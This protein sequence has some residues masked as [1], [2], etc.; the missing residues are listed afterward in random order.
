MGFH[1]TTF[2][3]LAVF[4]LLTVFSAS[5]Q[6]GCFLLP[7]SSS[8]CQSL[9]APSA[10]DECSFF[11]SCIL[12]N[13]F[14]PGESC[15]Q[16][17]ECREILCKSS[18]TP[19]LAGKCPAGPVLPGEESQWCSPGCCQYSSSGGISCGPVATKWECETGARHQGT[20]QYR[21]ASL[22]EPECVSLCQ[23]NVTAFPQEQVS[24]TGGEEQHQNP[25]PA[26]VWIIIG[27][28][29]LVLLYT[30]VHSLIRRKETSSPVVLEK[31]LRWYSFLLP[32]PRTEARLQQLHAHHA[33]ALQ[34]KEREEFLSMFG[35]TPEF[36]HS[37]F[38]KL[39]RLIQNHERAKAEP[40]S[41]KLFRKLESLTASTPGLA[42]IRPFQGLSNVEREKIIT[43]LRAIITRQK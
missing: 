43:N 7:E 29:L 38:P 40:D 2:I 16:F 33:R 24:S 1:R 31:P 30:L 28:V 8:Y 39:Q 6:E 20:A 19:Q 13:V 25:P 26:I 37:E 21:F 35:L 36:I 34:E 41:S 11:P 12:E 3:F 10:G 32:G 42:V 15:A 17:P 9:S 5:A 22:S 14:H 18:C 23:Q 4:F 27:L